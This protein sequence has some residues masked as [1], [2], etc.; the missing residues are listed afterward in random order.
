MSRC[1]AVVLV[2]I[3]LT[4]VGCASGRGGSERGIEP[5]VAR[6][7]SIPNEKL[8]GVIV[9]LAAPQVVDFA[10]MIQRLSDARVVCVGEAHDNLEHHLLQRDVIEALLKQRGQLAVGMEMFQNHQGEPLDAYTLRGET[11]EKTFVRNVDYYG[12]WGF[13][14]SLY[15]PILDAAR[16]AKLPVVGLNVKREIVRKVARGGLKSLSTEECAAIPEVDT[17]NA[18]HKEYVLKRFGGHEGRGPMS[19]EFFYE[20][21]CLWDEYMAESAAAFLRKPGNEKSN[22]VVV[23]GNGHIEYK[24]NIPDRLAKRSGLAVKTVVA[25]HVEKDEKLDFTELLKSGIADFVV[26]TGPPAAAEERPMLGVGLGEAKEAADASGAKVTGVSLESVMPDSPAAEAGLK[27]GDVIVRLADTEITSATDVRYALEGHKIGDTVEV[28]AL[29][30]GQRVEVM[31][32]LKA[33]KQE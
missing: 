15:R 5:T 25:I 18:E 32:A 29:R 6:L 31:V 26:F 2:L 9:D 33:M 10:T 1:L 19:A 23:A 8:A 7:G 12:T 14:Y 20:A 4:V 11:D 22:M 17:G 16:A 3:G 28:T 27:S 21:Q 30:D 24:F 13:S